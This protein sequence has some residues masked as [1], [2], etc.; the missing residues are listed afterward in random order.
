METVRWQHAGGGFEWEAPFSL[1]M[2]VLNV[3]PDSFSDGGKFLSAERAVEQ[4][5]RLMEAKAL[6]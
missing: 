6:T 1:L 2:G 3:T 4:A 5:Q